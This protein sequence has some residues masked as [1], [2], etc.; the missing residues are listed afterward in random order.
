MKLKFPAEAF[1][2]GM[3]LLSASMLDAFAYGVLVIFA[4]VLAEWLKN[5]LEGRIPR[6]SLYASIMIATGAVLSSVFGWT[7]FWLGAEKGWMSMLYGGLIGLLAGKACMD[8]DWNADYGSIAWESSLVWVG[9]ILCGI[10]REFL[11]SG[12]V[13]GNL[14]ASPFF[15]SAVISKTAFGFLAAGIALAAVQVLIRKKYTGSDSLFVIV[16]VVCLVQPFAFSLDPKILG[17]AL[18]AAVTLVFA[19]SVRKITAFSQTTAAFQKLPVDLISMGLVY[20]ILGTY[21]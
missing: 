11:A 4:A 8:G 14:L 10:F 18:A 21:K 16:P 2:L 7:D 9:W 17:M 15:K 19:V 3:I 6:W 5:L 1:A 12:T 13:A 20:L